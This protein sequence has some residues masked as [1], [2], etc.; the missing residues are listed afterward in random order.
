[1][2]VAEFDRIVRLGLGR[3]ILYLRYHDWRPYRDVIL[4]ACLCNHAWD[5][6]V[7]GT[8]SHY[9]WSLIELTDDRAYFRSKLLEALKWTGNWRH[10]EHRIA[11]ASWFVE[12]GDGEVLAAMYECVGALLDTRRENIGTKSLIEADGITAFLFIAER[13][14]EELLRSDDND[15]RED[16]YDY[17][18]ACELIGEHEVNDAL[19]KR[20]SED[21]RVAAYKAAVEKAIEDD[22]IRRSERKQRPPHPEFRFDFA[23]LRQRINDGENGLGLYPMRLWARYASDDDVL[24]AAYAVRRVRR[25][26]RLLRYIWAF[27]EKAFPLS[28][29]IL[30][31]LARHPNE[32]VAWAALGALEKIQHPDVRALTLQ[33]LPLSNLSHG[34]IDLLIANYQPGDECI[35]L[36]AI[37]RE[38]KKHKLHSLGFDALK[39]FKANPVPATIPVLLALY[40]R[41]PCS[42]CRTG[43]VKQIVALN[44]LPDWMLEECL[45]DSQEHIRELAEQ[46]TNGTATT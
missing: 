29:H 19:A 25:P 24:Q 32:D 42:N 27:H 45:H 17:L 40:E 5:A 21:L 14:G 26:S 8:R 15:D 23:T 2:T 9:A 3:A 39:V 7:E 16:E 4:Q 35:I 41:T 12:Q 38:R 43:C 37:R 28:P 10:I 13:V 18:A 36:E 22:N 34:A 33:L 1:M 6:Q 11:L 44:A 30:I 46:L 31:A 20:A